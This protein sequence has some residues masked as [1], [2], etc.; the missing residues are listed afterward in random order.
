MLEKVLEVCESVQG[1]FGMTLAAVADLNGD[2]LQDLA[3]G[4]PLE[5]DQKG[6]MYIYLGNEQQGIRSK[7]SQVQC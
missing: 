1:R 3:V 6:A 2:Q 4:A 5:D 7:F